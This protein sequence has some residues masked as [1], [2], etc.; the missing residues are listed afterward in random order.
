MTADQEHTKPVT[1]PESPPGPAVRTGS[2]WRTFGIVVITIVVTLI[3]AYWLM[4]SVLFPDAFTPVTLNQQEQQQ[5]TQ[6]LDRLHA[7]S[8]PDGRQA[9]Q[10]EPYSEE[11]AS[12]EIVFTEKELNAMLARNTDLASK[13]AIDLADNLASANLLVDL[14]PDLPFVGGNTLKVT[15]GMELKVSNG[16]PRAVVKGVSLWGVPLPNAWL[17]NLKNKDLIQEFGEAG[18]FWQAINDG[19][20]QIEV[21]NGS[22]RIRLKE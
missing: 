9:V 4:S 20:E 16:R 22:L 11:G 17:G 15:A 21:K 19:V 7:D 1:G 12:R 8:R 5:L 14:D 6:K 3:A 10:P 2:G 13:L 18:G